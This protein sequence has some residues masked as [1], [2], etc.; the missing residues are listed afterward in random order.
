M[1]EQQTI[2]IPYETND[3][4]RKMAKE[5]GCSYNSLILVLIDLGIRSYRTVREAESVAKSSFQTLP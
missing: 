3:G 5:I 4:I 1:K 2:R